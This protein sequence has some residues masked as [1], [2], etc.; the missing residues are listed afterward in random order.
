[1]DGGGGLGT[2]LGLLFL[3][4][5]VTVCGPIAGIILG[6]VLASKGKEITGFPLVGAG[7]LAGLALGVLVR[8]PAGV[9]DAALSRSAVVAMVAA[10]AGLVVGIV[11]AVAGTKIRGVGLPVAGALTGLGLGVVLGGLTLATGGTV[12]VLLALAPIGIALDIYVVTPVRRA[13][14]RF[15]KGS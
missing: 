15:L 9:T 12:A 14:L 1:M 2:A 3:G 5:A 10:A 7:G 6:I 11:L 8:L 4:L 13:I